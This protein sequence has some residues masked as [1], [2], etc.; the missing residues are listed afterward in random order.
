MATSSI[1]TNPA[2]Q[3]LKTFVNNV[4][5][6]LTCGANLF[7]IVMGSGLVA[8]AP[9]GSQFAATGI[10]AGISAGIIGVA[11]TS[12][13]SKSPSLISLP[14]SSLA[15]LVAGLFA[16]LGADPEI[17]TLMGGYGGD[18]GAFYLGVIAISVILAGV[19]QILF[20]VLRLGVLVTFIPYP[21]VAGFM[22]GI[23]CLI[24]LGQLPVILGAPT[25]GGLRSILQV[26]NTMLSVSAAIGAAV[27]C[28]IL[29][30]R[31]FYKTTP[32][33]LIGI[34]MG[35]VVF[36]LFFI[37]QP[38]ATLIPPVGEVKA[39]LPTPGGFIEL[40]QRLNVRELYV[41]LTKIA[42]T[43]VVIALIGS[44]QSLLSLTVVD[45]LQG[46]RTD[47]NRELVA[48][49]C[50][51]IAS[52]LFGGLPSS[53]S[54]GITRIIH[55]MGATAKAVTVIS[56]ICLLIVVTQVPWIMQYIPKAAVAAVIMLG[57][58]AIIDGW[59][60]QLFLR[61]V[62]QR[63]PNVGRALLLSLSVS[64]FVTATV[65][66]VGIIEAILAGM[67]ISLLVFFQRSRQLVLRRSCFGDMVHS[68]TGRRSE[69]VEYLKDHGRR[70][71]V[72]EIQGPVFFGTADQLAEDIENVLGDVDTVI[73]D[74]RRVSDIDASGAFVI[75]RFDNLFDKYGKTL[76]LSHIPYGASMQEFLVNMGLEKLFRENRVLDDMDSALRRAEDELLARDGISLRAES[77]VALHEFEILK[78]F[79][80]AE[81]E[82]LKSRMSRCD[83]AAGTPV[84]AH[85]STSDFLL[86]LVRGSVAIQRPLIEDGRNLLLATRR[87]GVILGE[88]A[89][90]TNEARSADVCAQTDVVGYKLEKADFEIF[91]DEQPRAGMHLIRN[92]AGVLSLRVT[93]LLG[94]IENL[95][96]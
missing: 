64:L 67:V 84:M 75:R 74:F 46:V 9:L 72:F 88:M 30:V 21:V 77:E 8:I 15:I 43:A 94:T 14:K 52:G 79:S 49:G 78:G 50:G 54:I 51:Q 53:G 95:E 61:V 56:G 60:R 22:N 47:R 19:L 80:T 96:Q 48:Q 63:K 28:S 93:D 2:R 11:V 92:I 59:S 35:V 34:C 27:I 32:N 24:F 17:R 6:G 18:M 58:L 4:L 23:A 41:L 16:Q 81:L 73:L 5:G 44:F 90:L 69:E 3:P 7:P 26:D 38:V 1:P 29:V 65:L 31:R 71:A 13:T 12:L 37:S 62:I 55:Q 82:A 10:A 66:L 45:T 91:C 89:L 36:Q 70:I 25:G 40:F 87:A 33:A 86:F 20:A 42:G 83:Y 39:S 68:R 85:G 76:L 57:S